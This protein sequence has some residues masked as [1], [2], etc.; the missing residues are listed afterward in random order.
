MVR[1]HAADD[2][3]PLKK[4]LASLAVLLVSLGVVACGS[5]SGASSSA[6]AARPQGGF[7]ARLTAAQRSCMKT[8]GVA[9]PAGRRGGRPP[10][11]ANGA[12]PAGANGAP[13]AGR[14]PGANRNSAQAK[15][16]RAAFK[17][18]G[19]QAPARPGAP[20]ASNG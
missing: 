10:G 3:L 18:C 8:Q 7:G 1:R 20:A 6:G 2:R 5:S 9:L 16:L 15:K 12:P 19:I 13:P 4:P 11:G 17:A 14:F